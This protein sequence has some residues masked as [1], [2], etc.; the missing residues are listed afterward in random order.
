MFG[1]MF[2]NIGEQVSAEVERS[3]HGIHGGHGSHG[4]PGTKHGPDT[5]VSG[6]VR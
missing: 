1:D 3:L 2:G 5:H 4:Q 6:W